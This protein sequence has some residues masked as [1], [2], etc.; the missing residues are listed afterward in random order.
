M[1]EEQQP[2][3]T[4]TEQKTKT[5]TNTKVIVA[6]VVGLAIIGG[7]AFAFFWIKESPFREVASDFAKYKPVGASIDGVVIRGEPIKKPCECE[8]NTNPKCW[9]N[10]GDE[11]LVY[12]FNFS[13]TYSQN[14]LSKKEKN[15]EAQETIDLI[16]KVLQQRTAKKHII[17]LSSLADYNTFMDLITLENIIGVEI[18][19]QPSMV[20][21]ND[22]SNTNGNDNPEC[23]DVGC[24]GPGVGLCILCFDGDVD[25][26]YCFG[27]GAKISMANGSSMDIKNI[28][29]GDK[30][31]SYDID[32]RKVVNS[33]VINKFTNKADEYLVINGQLKVT[34]NHKFYVNDQ[35]MAAKDIKEGD[36]ILREN[37]A[38]EMVWEIKQE[39]EPIEVYNIGV[40]GYNN[41]FAEGLLVHNKEV[42]VTGM[43][44]AIWIGGNTGSGNL[45]DTCSWCYGCW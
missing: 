4:K 44:F 39:K 28:K 27:E 1:N 15:A 22:N 32:K 6:V 9:C 31:K 21:Q 12:G 36:T 35:W 3:E 7:G 26:D 40:E 34:P 24:A 37:D 10:E 20:F 41:Y 29:I 30:V 13:D 25:V 16:K 43:N 11:T 42:E 18:E 38:K 23:G 45:C 19:D 2:T 5:K 8:N 14:N 33:K 17:S